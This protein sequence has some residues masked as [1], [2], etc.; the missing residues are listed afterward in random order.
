[1][2]DNTWC[3]GGGGGG[4]RVDFFRD[5]LSLLPERVEDDDWDLEGVGG[6]GR[7]VDFERC[8]RLLPVF[9]VLEE[10]D[11]VSVSA[12]EYLSMTDF[13]VASIF[14]ICFMC[15]SHADL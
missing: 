7:F 15:A 14:A 1:M 13:R 2:S 9:D 8:R 6:G 10:T 3:S 12:S 4:R 5:L 11:I